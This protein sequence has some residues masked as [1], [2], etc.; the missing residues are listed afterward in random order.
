MSIRFCEMRLRL[1]QSQLEIAGV[2]WDRVE[3]VISLVE[4]RAILFIFSC[5]ATEG[6]MSWFFFSFLVPDGFSGLLSML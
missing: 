2:S 1:S 5:S 6:D 4:M 3:A